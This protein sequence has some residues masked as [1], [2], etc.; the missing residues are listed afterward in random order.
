MH[1]LLVLWLFTKNCDGTLIMD[2]IV[3]TYVV[4]TR[5]HCIKHQ[6]SEISVE[7]ENYL[8]TFHILSL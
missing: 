7:A 3:N 4:Q 6:V 5:L 2:G 8:S 1:C